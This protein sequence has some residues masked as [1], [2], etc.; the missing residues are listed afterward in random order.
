MKY[1]FIAAHAGQ[2]HIQRM[3][4]VLDVPRSGYYAW[5]RRTPSSRAQANAALLA[6]IQTEYTASRKTYG[7]PR[8]QA[9]LQRKGIVCGHNR[10]A[11]LM[12]LHALVGACH[13]RKAGP[14]TTQRAPGVVPA[15]NLLNQEFSASAPNRKWVV[16]FSYIETRE[17]WLYLA[18]VL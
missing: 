2:F 3:C 18:V 1:I 17:G 12:R 7:S 13:R 14:V 6:L 9:V 11:R 15:P 8:I 4:R 5:Q 16:D 10:V